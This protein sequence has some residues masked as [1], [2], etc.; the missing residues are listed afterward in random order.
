MLSWLASQMFRLHHDSQF[1][2]EIH[3]EWFACVHLPCAQLCGSVL[4]P[5]DPE[6]FCIESCRIC[7]EPYGNSHVYWSYKDRHPKPL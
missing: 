7:A 4:I 5:A 6:G 2:L 1:T 3:R